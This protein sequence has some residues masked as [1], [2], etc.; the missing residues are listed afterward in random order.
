MNNSSI[1][2]PRNSVARTGKKL[3]A[4]FSFVSIAFLGRRARPVLDGR[5]RASGGCLAQ[6]SRATAKEVASAG[7]PVWEQYEPTWA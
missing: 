5:W 3:G 1:P 2:Q 7:L 6:V 4:L